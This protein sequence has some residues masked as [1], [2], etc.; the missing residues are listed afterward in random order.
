MSENDSVQNSDVAT[1]GQTFDQ[2]VDKAF[3]SVNETEFGELSDD[4]LGEDEL[5]DLNAEDDEGVEGSGEEPPE[6]EGGSE[7]E[8]K[9][10]DG[11]DTPVE[12]KI[13]EEV[14]EEVKEVKEEDEFAPLR[15]AGYKA[16][17]IEALVNIAQNNEKVRAAIQEAISGPSS[18]EKIEPPK[19]AVEKTPKDFMPEGKQYSSVDALETG[20]ESFKAHSQYTKYLSSQ[21]FDERV[22]EQTQSH[23]KEMTAQRQAQNLRDGAKVLKDKYNVTDEEIAEFGKN[24][25]TT[26]TEEINPLK[27]AYLGMNFERLVEARVKKAVELELDKFSET[28]IRTKHT[29]KI[30]S[31]ASAETGHAKGTAKSIGNTVDDYEK[32]QFGD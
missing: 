24:I 28:Q 15:N 11:V 8:P 27:V 1:D 25:K 20:T 16:E 17:N 31:S 3:D 2:A 32:E 6:E 26:P 5:V 12:P 9:E 21:A 23:Q 7:E 14:K 10:E 13:E 4:D 18:E 30:K 19:E 22:A 29:K